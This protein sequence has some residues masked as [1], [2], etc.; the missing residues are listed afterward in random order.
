MQPEISVNWFLAQAV[1]CVGAWLTGRAIGRNS[2]A[3]GE[4]LLAT[5][6]ALS[7][8]W[9]LRDRAAAVLLD[10]FPLDSWVYLEGTVIAPPVLLVAGALSVHPHQRRARWLGPALAVFGAAYFAF[11]G[12]WML[13][14]MPHPATLDTVR[15]TSGATMQS[16]SDSCSAAAMATALRAYNLGFVVSEADMARFAD[17]RAGAGATPARVVRG[18]RMA[19]QGTALEPR[20]VSL[21]AAEV[22]H[23]ASPDMPALV[24]LRTGGAQHHMVVLYGRVPGGLLRVFNPSEGASQGALMDPDTF[25]RRYTGSAIVMLPRDSLSRSATTLSAH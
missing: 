21:S 4:I 12:A 23:V 3:W 25:R 5:L 1:L 15:H 8:A 20:L 9:A 19:M 2:H 11:H 10:F 17:L 14:P 18:L 6:A 24:T 13:R 16:R 22:A 7:V